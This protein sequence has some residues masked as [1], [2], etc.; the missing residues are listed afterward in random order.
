MSS[1]YRNMEAPT[2]PYQWQEK[3]IS[4][5]ASR[6]KWAIWGSVIG[7]IALIAIGVGVG[8][9]VSH[10]HGGTASNRSSSGSNSNNNSVVPQ[11][12]PNDP[13]TFVKDSRLKQSFYGMA[14]TPS[15]S[16]LPNCNNSLSDVIED[17][18]LISQLTTRIRLYGA[19]CNQSAVVLEAIKQTKVNLSVFLGNYP[20]PTDNGVAYKRQRDLIVDAINTY[21]TD[22][23]AGITVGNEWMLNYLNANGATDPNGPVGNQGAQ[24]LIANIQDTIST[25][26]S[27]NLPK[28]I[29]VGT[30]D[31]GAY[32]NTQVLQAVEY[33]MSNV[34]PWFANVSIDQA[35]GWTNEFFQQQNAQPAAALSNH[36]TM[37]IAET[38]W[39][40]ESS[41]AG[42]ANNGPSTA[43][44]GNLQTFLDTFVCQANQN[45]TGYFYF[46]F[47]DE[48]WKDQQF[49]GVEGWWGLFTSNKT[50]KGITIPTCS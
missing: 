25:L 44:I 46:E 15:G 42:N 9:A 5:G 11:T 20:I 13:S 22:H 29:P 34:H 8:V 6:R 43:S 38:G 27:M 36:P 10:K 7:L 3:Y 37:Y 4:A 1:T 39:P 45:G 12:N 18:Q 50:L 21:G 31:A 2:E 47:F 32:F 49:G 48:V 24:L 28:H 14:Y 17:I 35:A 26:N 19:D 41:D 40:T 23:I 16:Q 30:A 33:G